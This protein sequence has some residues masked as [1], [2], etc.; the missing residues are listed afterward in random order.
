MATGIDAIQVGAPVTATGGVSFAPTDTTLPTDATTSLDLSFIKG[1]FIGEDGV[2]RT[3]DASDENI[4]A[5]GGDAVKVVRTEHSIS[6]T[7]AFLESANADVLRL[8]HGDE[9][10]TVT[11]AGVEVKQTKKM[12]PRRTF[13]LDMMDGDS[14]IREVIPNGQIA[15]SGDVTFVHSDVVRYEVT[16]TAFPATVGGTSDVKAVT[17]IADTSAPEV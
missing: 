8:I 13:V 17:Y 5:W 12:A 3:T 15:S 2:T 10:V 9:N 4:I 7:F 16:I 11:A 14:R 1:G 6:Y